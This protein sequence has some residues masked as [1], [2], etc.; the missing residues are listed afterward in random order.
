VGRNVDRKDREEKSKVEALK[1]T[2]WENT[3]GN[4]IL[5]FFS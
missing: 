3:H 1:K 2:Y 4:V 5:P